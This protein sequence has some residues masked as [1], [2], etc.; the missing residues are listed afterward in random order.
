MTVTTKLHHGSTNKSGNYTYPW[1]HNEQTSNIGVH[2][3]NNRIYIHGS[4]VSSNDMFP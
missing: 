4:T 1:I 2:E 3:G